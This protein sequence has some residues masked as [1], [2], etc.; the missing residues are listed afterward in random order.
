MVK[1]INKISYKV[2]NST[3]V[4]ISLL[5]ISSHKHEVRKL[6]RE[7]KLFKL[8]F[9]SEFFGRFWKGRKIVVYFC[10]LVKLIKSKELYY[11]FKHQPDLALILRYT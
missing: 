11:F 8:L 3:T 5:E 1:S 2:H 7:K 10:D 6:L 9:S 4:F